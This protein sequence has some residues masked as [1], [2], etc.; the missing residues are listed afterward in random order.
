MDSTIGA[1]QSDILN[2]ETH[3]KDALYRAYMAV[4]GG[5]GRFVVTPE[6]GTPELN[7]ENLGTR[8]LEASLEY[9][10]AAA[11]H[12]FPVA[13]RRMLDAHAHVLEIG[14]DGGEFHSDCYDSV[15][16]VQTPWL[17]LKYLLQDVTA[18]N[19]E[20][21]KLAGEVLFAYAIEVGTL[22]QTSAADIQKAE[23]AFGKPDAT[24]SGVEHVPYQQPATDRNGS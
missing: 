15:S 14:G 7:Q 5:M 17:E 11:V 9:L 24:F 3:A 18:T 4:V 21:V 19:G 8:D 20:L 22:D 1:L 2:R 10:E 16:A 6:E 13:A 12:S 23:T